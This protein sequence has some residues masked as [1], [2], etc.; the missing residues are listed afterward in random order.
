MSVSISP[1]GVLTGRQQTLLYLQAALMSFGMVTP[2][3]VLLVLAPGQLGAYQVFII[4]GALV[5]S[6]LLMQWQIQAR[7]AGPLPSMRPD[8]PFGIFLVFLI[9]F[10]VLNYT[11]SW[12]TGAFN[13]TT[14]EPASKIASEKLGA[15][16][17]E[18]VLY[19]IGVIVL[20]PVS[21][22][23]IFRHFLFQAFLP[24]R[25]RLRLAL[26]VLL[27]T[28]AFVAMHAQYV[29]P[30]T[31]ISIGALALLYMLAR[32][33]TNGLLLPITLHAMN[34][35]LATTSQYQAHAAL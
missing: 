13:M 20:A 16:M 22:E 12:A 5:G 8:Y 17:T 21:E 7:G 29:H 3:A 2:L 6:A 4:S 31:F 35:L 19:C 24:E 15:S 28:A 33:K 32:L 9:A 30:M 11:L 18:Q 26:A 10:L 25:S 34:N 23:I 1:T 14:G 27:T